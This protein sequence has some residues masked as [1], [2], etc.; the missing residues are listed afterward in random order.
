LPTPVRP[1]IANGRQG[2]SES[3]ATTRGLMSAAVGI[4][5]V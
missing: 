5:R 1:L 2:R 3:A 4:A